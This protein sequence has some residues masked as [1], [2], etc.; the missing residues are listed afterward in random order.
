MNGH[1]KAEN[2]DHVRHCFFSRRGG[3]SK[4]IYGSLNCGPG[5]HDDPANVAEN[6]RIVADHIAGRRDTPLVSVY[7]IHSAH[8]I[9]VDSD[10][11]D[12]RPKADALVTNRPGIILGILTADCTPILFSDTQNNVIA[13][14]HAGWKGALTGVIE[15]TLK[16][17]ESLGSNR[18]YINAAIG[19]T[20]HQASYEVGLEFKETFLSHDSAYKRFFIT[21]KDD[22]HLQFDL[23]AFVRHRLDMA[24]ITSIWQSTTDTYS[25][26]NHFSYRLTTHNNEEDYGRQISAIMLP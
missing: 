23:P 7:Q 19:P 4:G 20:I 1:E 8:A 16:L 9:Y 15:N 2:L 24:G 17:M 12:D 11:G 18:A 22:S 26:Q 13:A 6:R 5:S 25:S 10:W 21:G 14:A 3:V